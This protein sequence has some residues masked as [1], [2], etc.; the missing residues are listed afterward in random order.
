MIRHLY[1]LQKW[2]PNK[3]NT[4]VSVIIPNSYITWT[5]F[6]LLY[7]TSLWL[8]YNYQFIV[9]NPFTYVPILSSIWWLSIWVSMSLFLFCILI[10]FTYKWNMC[11]LYFSDLF[12]SAQYLLGSCILLQMIRFHFINGCAIFF[13][14]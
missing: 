14:I 2:P 6:S 12:Y 3:S 11:H 7:F 13:C 1:N 4:I 5:V 8:F 10:F 9:F